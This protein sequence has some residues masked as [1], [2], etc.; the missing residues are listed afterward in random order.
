MPQVGTAP[1]STA[2]KVG[3]K[4]L[5]WR[6]PK[7][8]WL[9]YLSRSKWI[10]SSAASRPRSNRSKYMYLSPKD[11]QVSQ[12]HLWRPGTPPLS[13]VLCDSQQLLGA[14]SDELIENLQCIKGL[15]KKQTIQQPR[16]TSIWW[17]T[18][19][20][21]ETNFNQEVSKYGELKEEK[22]F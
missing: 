19:W 13:L 17:T 6:K 14:G 5:P 9:K 16:N 20:K 8:N 15:L 7:P 2:A 1:C 3:S 12:W 22:K 10:N 21:G 11:Q 18:R 4:R